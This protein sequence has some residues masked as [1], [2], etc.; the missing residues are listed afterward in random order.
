LICHARC[1]GDTNRNPLDFVDWEA[2]P[3]ILRLST[4][5]PLSRNFE[6]DRMGNKASNARGPSPV[7]NYSAAIAG[8]VSSL[9]D[10]YL[11]AKPISP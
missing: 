1:V 7:A 8:A 5:H 9:G 2:E 10:R 6:E 11:L 3:I 4:S